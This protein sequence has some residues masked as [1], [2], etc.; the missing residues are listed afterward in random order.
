MTES[1][2]LEADAAAIVV[3]AD[4]I[5]KFLSLALKNVHGGAIV[6]ALMQIVIEV[7]Q[8]A[9]PD[10]QRHSCDFIRTLLD[11]VSNSTSTDTVQ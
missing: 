7:I 1:E 11:S 2:Q 3:Q 4:Q 10:I 8:Q 9:P 6:S 5:Y